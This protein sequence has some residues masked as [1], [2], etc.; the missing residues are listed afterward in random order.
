MTIREEDIPICSASCFGKQSC[1]SPNTDGLGAV[2]AD[3]YYQPVMCISIDKIESPQ[4]GLIS[5][6]KGKQTSRKYTIVT[7][8][9]DYFSK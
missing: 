7:I 9:V 8:Y 5:V 3:E 1:T 6:I 4:G 2:I